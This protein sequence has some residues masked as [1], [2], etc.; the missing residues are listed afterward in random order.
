MGGA[1]GGLIATAMTVAALGL[2]RAQGGPDFEL[3][4]SVIAGGMNGSV[5]GGNFNLSGVVGQP[6]ATVL[7]GGSLTLTGGFVL[8]A[9]LGDA[10]GDGFVGPEDVARIPPCLSGPTNRTDT[11]CNGLDTDG[12]ADVDLKDMAEF[13]ANYRRP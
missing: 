2:T 12:D 13:Q 10:T 6:A 7:A 1:F 9:M 5:T 11:N 4:R 3:T 8:P